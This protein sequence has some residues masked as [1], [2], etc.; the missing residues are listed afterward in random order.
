MAIIALC[1][2]LVGAIFIAKTDF[3]E[4]M[5]IEPASDH[6]LVARAGVGTR[7]SI[8]AVLLLSHNT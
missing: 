4:D 6:V 8:S 1:G 5:I 2:V 7:A 3:D